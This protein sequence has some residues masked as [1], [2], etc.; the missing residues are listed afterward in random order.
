M[1]SGWSCVGLTA[2]HVGRLLGFNDFKIYGYDGSYAGG[3]RTAGA[4]LGI[5]HGR[6]KVQ[7][8]GREFETSK[9]MENANIELQYLIQNYPIT[10]TFFGDGC[11]QWWVKNANLPNMKAE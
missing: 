6:V 4:H 7:H 9:M 8:A 3:D 2:F 10:G 11:N 1:V 5:K